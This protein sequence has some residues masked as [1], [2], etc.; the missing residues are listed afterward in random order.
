MRNTWMALAFGKL[1]LPFSSL[2]WRANAKPFMTHYNALGQD[3]YLRIAFEL[4]LKRLFQVDMRECT[5]LDETS[6]T[7]DLTAHTAQ[8]LP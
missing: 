4:Y 7:K 6:E 2:V 8:S 3:M 1:K 5:K